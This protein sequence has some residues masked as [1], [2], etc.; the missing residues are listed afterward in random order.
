MKTKKPKKKVKTIVT[1]KTY[2]S[3]VP[4]ANFTGKVK[5]VDWR[6]FKKIVKINRYKNGKLVQEVNT[7][8]VGKKENY[9]IWTIGFVINEKDEYGHEVVSTINVTSFTKQLE[10]KVLPIFYSQVQQ[11]KNFRIS[12]QK[13]GKKQFFSS[14][15][16][17]VFVIEKTNTPF[18]SWVREISK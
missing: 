7:T 5:F 8:T 12:V 14:K 15:K 10:E 18:I 11:N 2:F 1:T 9:P 16:G 3:Y 4:K 17:S 6:D 13:D